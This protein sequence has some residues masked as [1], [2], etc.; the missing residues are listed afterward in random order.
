MKFAPTTT[1][2]L[3]LLLL[4]GIACAQQ[5][6]TLNIDLSKPLH[7]VSPTLYGLM[8]EEINYSYDGGLYAEMVRN[9]A[10]R[11]HGW[12]GLANWRLV[13]LGHS[14]ASLAFDPT[15][16]PSDALQSSLKLEVKQADPANQAGLLNNGWW[17][18]AVRANT[19]YKGSF[20]AKADSNDL[21][22]VSVSL[23]GD[24]SGD[25]L[26]AATSAPLTTEWKR[27]DFT[28]KTGNVATSAE[29]HLRLSV[30]H[31]GTLWIDLVSLFPPTYHDRANG[32]RPDLMEKMAAMKPA[33]LRLPGGN[34]LEGDDIQ[35]RYDWKKTIGPLVDRPTH[36]SPWNYQSSDGMGLL[37]FLEWCEDLK[38][39]PVLAVYAG[40]SL[41]GAHIEPGP[42]LEPFVDDALDEIEFVSGDTSTK[43]G[44]VRAKLGHPAPFP[45]TYVEIGN[46]D[47][48]DRSGSYE[49]RYAQFYKAIKAKYPSLQLIATMPLKRMKPDVIDDHYYKQATDFF[50]MTDH[51]DTI[52][53][54][55]PKIF[56]G[57]WATREGAPATN[58]GA[59]L[60][61]AAWM[62]GMERNS[63]L[64]VLASYAPL[65]VN[66]NPGGMQWES[67]LIGYDA[68]TSYGSPGY[69]AQAM[70]A[71]HL[72]TSV[73]ASSLTGAPDRV[74]YSVTNDPAKHT[75]DIKLVNA[76]SVPQPVEIHL[77]GESKLAKSAILIS[78]EGHTTA[79]TN[80]IDHPTRIVPK[81]T[82][83]K[84]P[85]GNLTHVVPPYSIQIIELKTE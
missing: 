35:D 63:D 22:P 33:F 42:Y 40:Y 79:E 75:V 56:V 21:G 8:T 77:D 27:Y 43:W 78:L 51:Y 65:F 41:R 23:V 38:I 83:I 80:T 17:G 53:R 49:G 44:A 32:N 39:Q 36:P 62:T 9:R 45:L 26:A 81:M 15:T 73:P 74:F 2:T 58:L 1:G 10:V 6:A 52:D 69:Y 11:Q 66:V 46:E 72:G 25:Q 54:N 85:T 3:G 37:E 28:L 24:N 70:F 20:Y 71:N 55:G 7:P 13:E 47:N 5:P 30:G 34:Y 76:N 61:D 12:E 18:M 67:D 84:V 68:L 59:A 50:K 60:G 57:E 14:A 4:A 16:G 31:Q 29:N 64:I 48:F 19:E 82:E